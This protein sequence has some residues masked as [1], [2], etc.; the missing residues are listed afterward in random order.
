MTKQN[1]QMVLDALNT[2]DESANLEATLELLTYIQPD[3][4]ELNDLA[5]SGIKMAIQALKGADLRECIDCIDFESAKDD[6]SF[7]N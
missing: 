4:E 7:W 6:P 3:V 2:D 5:G 1:K